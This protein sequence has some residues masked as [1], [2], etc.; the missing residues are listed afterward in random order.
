MIE[1]VAGFLFSE[2]GEYVALVEKQKPE[3][4]KG[5]YNAIGGKIE[6]GISGKD[7]KVYFFRAF[8]DKVHD[9]ETMET[10]TICVFHNEEL[11]ELNKIPNL[12]WLIP[13]ALDTENVHCAFVQDK[14]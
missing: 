10:E 7:W 3:W 13:M 11:Y 1:Y 5:K 8:S 2:D 12:N 4:Q 14:K 9:V 6:A